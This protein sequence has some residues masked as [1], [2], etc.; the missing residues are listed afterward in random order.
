M[1]YSSKALKF[2][3]IAYLQYNVIIGD[4]LWVGFHPS[5]EGLCRRLRKIRYFTR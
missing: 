2:V 1:E 5:V 4:Y 3:E